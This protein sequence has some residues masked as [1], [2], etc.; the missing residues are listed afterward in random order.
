MK[1][2]VRVLKV[3][4]SGVGEGGRGDGGV[5]EGGPGEGGAGDGVAGE[6][7]AETP[8][9]IKCWADVAGISSA[10]RTNTVAVM[11]GSVEPGLEGPWLLSRSLS[12]TFIA[13]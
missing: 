10:R 7:D 6:G 11:E 13:I 3:A 5:G 9:G 2:K 1:L 4:I 12:D 8:V